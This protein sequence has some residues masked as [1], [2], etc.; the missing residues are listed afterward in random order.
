[1]DAAAQDIHNNL[2]NFLVNASPLKNPQQSKL[3]KWFVDRSTME[4]LAWRE[5]MIA[6]YRYLHQHVDSRFRFDGGSDNQHA[7]NYII[8]LEKMKEKY[9]QRR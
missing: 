9:E 3:Y 7:K 6:L 4:T 2:R 8:I 5:G 1:V